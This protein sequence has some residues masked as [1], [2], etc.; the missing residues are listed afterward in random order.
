VTLEWVESSD[1]VATTI[2]WYEPK[3]Q[4]AR[5]LVVFLPAM[6]ANVD[7]YTPVAE[8]WA[9]QG[10]RVAC[11]E[12]RGGK[13]SPLRAGRRVNFG[14]HALL[15]A[16]LATVLPHI[17][18]RAG[19]CPILLGGHS[20]GGQLALL[21]ASRY[22]ELIDG[23]FLLAGGSNY[24]GAM[25]S[26]VRTW[27][28]AQLWLARNITRTLGYFPGDRLGFGGVQPRDLMLDWTHEALTGE[29]RPIGVDVDYERR[30]ADVR[31][32]VLF[33]SL[34]G[35]ALV[36]KSSADFLASKLARAAVSCVELDATS[37]VTLHHFRWVKRPE[38]MLAVVDRWVQDDVMP[39]RS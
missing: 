2:A 35:D 3:A 15:D 17:K 7:Y 19:A 21:Y 29:Y 34:Q 8:A 14:Y 11:L 37:G 1:G 13:H 36:P 33:V 18:Q 16:D 28:R 23:V 39:A 10:F 32:P 6:G 20:L 9:A 22:P 4:S 12:R 24:Y 5:G 38:A 27:R 25:P 31:L 30:L 26:R